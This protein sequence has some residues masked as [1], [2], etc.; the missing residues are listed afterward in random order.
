MSKFIT[1]SIWNFTANFLVR[2]MSIVTFPFLVRFFLREDISIFKSFQAFILILLT[3][4]PIGTNILYLSTP[5]EDR[6][7][8]WNHFFFVSLIVACLLSIILFFSE[9]ITSFFIGDNLAG[10]LRILLIIIPLVEGLKG[11]VITKLSSILDFKGI[12]IALIIKQLILYS[13][14]IGFAL[15]NPSLDIL[16]FLVFFSEALEL[17][18][19]LRHANRMKINMMPYRPRDHL[20]Q[21]AKGEDLGAKGEE[22][23][24]YT[25]FNFDK[26]AKKFMFFSGM[27]QIILT[28][29]LQFPTILV[30]IVLGKTLAPEFQ[31][32][33]TAVT[34]PVSL[35]M[36]SI[37]KVSFPHYSNLREN[38][39]IISS[40][41]SVLFPVTFILFPVLLGIH[42]FAREITGIF[43]D[44]SWQY[45][46]FALQ[47]FPVLMI[48]YILGVP[49]TFISNIKQKPYINLTYSIFLLLSRILSIYFGFKLGGFKGTIIFFVAGDIVIRMIRLKVDMI[50]LSLPLKR[51]FS[52]ISYNI[53]SMLILF[54]LMWLGFYL[55]QQKTVSFIIALLISVSL[56]YYWEQVKVKT[57]IIKLRDAVLPNRFPVNHTHGK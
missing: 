54:V 23:D 41:F 27:E 52:S 12:S 44:R 55:T 26:I 42:F 25:R 37:A 36:N 3:I 15:L 49:S 35:V 34:V 32:P 50:L 21:S 30:V 11:I 8:R 51:F 17:L 48:S 24:I 47:V 6:E 1:S 43:F 22:G 9:T 4:I 19:L 40:L 5:K 56:N 29:A 16:L 14:I 33:F 13:G 53:F 18:M 10:S 31:L 38:D 20:I 39:K 57:L 7:S 46:G 45:A 2:L 28:F